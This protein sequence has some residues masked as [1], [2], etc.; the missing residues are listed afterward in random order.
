MRGMNGRSPVYNWSSIRHTRW[1]LNSRHMLGFW[2][3]EDVDLNVERCK[4]RRR[5]KMKGMG[6]KAEDG[7]GV[8]G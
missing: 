7:I 3:E 8:D 1:A 2:E 6:L 4:V 5:W